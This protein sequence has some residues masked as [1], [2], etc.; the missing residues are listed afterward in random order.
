MAYL[1]YILWFE[2][3]QFINLVKF[4]IVICHQH[5][6]YPLGHEHDIRAIYL[7]KDVTKHS[8]QHLLSQPRTEQKQI[9]LRWC[10]FRLINFL[11]IQFSNSFAKY[12]T[13]A[14]WL[15]TLTKSGLRQSC[16]LCLHMLLELW[17]FLT[18]CASPCTLKVGEV[19]P[20]SN[21]LFQDAAQFVISVTSNTS[22]SYT[23]T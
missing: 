18:S 6:T 1:K 23:A 11:K 15:H 16:S 4:K 12:F 8:R 20:E 17:S 14:G 22:L 19:L 10:I 2:V 21:N 13:G 5:W 3:N 7:N 9:N